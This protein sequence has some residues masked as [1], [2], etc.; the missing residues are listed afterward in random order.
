LDY[1]IVASFFSNHPSQSTAPCAALRRGFVTYV[2]LSTGA[3]ADGRPF[4][5]LND[6]FYLFFVAASLA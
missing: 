4:F 6:V 3:T 2:P 1:L 5:L